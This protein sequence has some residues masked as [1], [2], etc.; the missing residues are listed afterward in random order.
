V[1]IAKINHVKIYDE[2]FL[3]ESGDFVR[4][5][6]C[7]YKNYGL[8]FEVE[9]VD[10]IGNLSHDSFPKEIHMGIWDQFYLAITPLVHDSEW[11]DVIDVR[12]E[13]IKYFQPNTWV[14]WG[15]TQTQDRR[16]NPI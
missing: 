5:K 13:E 1:L 15:V 12:N 8:I 6:E 10:M 7:F 4:E 3:D 16:G 2:E 11:V 9:V 14:G